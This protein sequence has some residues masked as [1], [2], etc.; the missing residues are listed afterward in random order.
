MSPKV[1]AKPSSLVALHSDSH[2]L[3]ILGKFNKLRKEDLLCDITLVVEDMHFRAHKALLAASSEFF[4]LMLTEDQMSRPTYQLDGMAA[5]TFAAI[6]EFIYSAQVSVEPSSTEQLLAT[7]RLMEVHDLVKVLTEVTSSVAVVR[8]EEVKANQA[9]APHLSKCKRGRP[10]KNIT[11]QGAELEGSLAPRESSKETQ[12]GDLDCEIEVTESQ[13]KSDAEYS[14]VAH[15]QNKRKIRPPLKYRNFK[16]GSN[17]AGSKEPGK[18][19]RKRKYPNTEARC[20]D[21]NK[22]FKNHLFLKIHRRTH[23]GNVHKVL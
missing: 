7:A 21:C 14:P 2:K 5:K 12:A 4:S 3:S 17:T 11:L 20:E 1:I 23:T 13:P 16:V 15:Q 10:R 18:R 6:L 19:G 22:V 9:E 8:G